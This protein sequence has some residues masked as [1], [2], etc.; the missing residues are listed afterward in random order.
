MYFKCIRNKETGLFG[1]DHSSKF[2]LNMNYA[3]IFTYPNIL[4]YSNITEEWVHI[5]SM[6]FTKMFVP[7]QT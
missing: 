2:L 5:Y 3:V 6:E 1:F 4:A 7:L